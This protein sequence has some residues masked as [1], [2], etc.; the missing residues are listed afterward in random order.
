M[1]LAERLTAA[2]ALA[3]LF[4]A[5]LLLPAGTAQ[6]AEPRLL[7]TYRDWNAFTI[8]EGGGTVCWMA[9]K[10]KKQEG[11]YSRR[12]DAF[13]LVTHRPQEKAVDVVSFVAGYAFAEGSEV[14]VQVGGQSFKLFTDGDTAW[15][16]DDQTDRALA[17]AIRQG[18]TM[19]VRGTSSR[20]TR[21]VDTYSLSG[22]SAAYQ[23]IN[24]A[25]GISGG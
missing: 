14:T 23:A 7:G 25:C 6:A 1:R 8:D 15:A 9:S 3:T 13:A 2:T 20:G 12:D 21:T 4:L 22:T 19:V 18:T 10:P 24:K 11:D 17:Q 16:R 5:G